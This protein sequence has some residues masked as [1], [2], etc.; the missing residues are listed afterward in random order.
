MSA[1]NHLVSQGQD[2]GVWHTPDRF[3]SS[4]MRFAIC[5]NDSPNHEK[6]AAQEP[7]GRKECA[8][9]ARLKWSEKSLH[10]R[11]RRAPQESLLGVGGNLFIL[12]RVFHCLLPND[13]EYRGKDCLDLGSHSSLEC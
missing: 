7:H 2:D 10:F 8:A 12:F 3:R 1:L 5:V 6:K 11:R 13:L 9:P 4:R